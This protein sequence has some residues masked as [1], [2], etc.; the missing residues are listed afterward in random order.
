M[1]RLAFVTVLLAAAIAPCGRA[2]RP[3][4]RP[5]A[6]AALESLSALGGEWEGKMRSGRFVRLSYRLVA[7]DSVL[8]EAFTTAS[9][10]ETLTLFHR[11][12]ER[13]LATHYCA[14]RN[15]P[16]LE[17]REAGPDGRLVFEFVDATNLAAAA[18]HL[19]RLEMQIVDADHF[20]K[21]ETYVDGDGKD[22]VTTYECA[23]ASR[24]GGPAGAPDGR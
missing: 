12:G 13:V 1:P 20:R 7:N 5:D 8:V 11:D 17:L 15:Q 19:R 18:S 22:E 23:R 24:T 4:A 21:T 16:R 6:A 10:R 9:N 3:P 14:L 2:D